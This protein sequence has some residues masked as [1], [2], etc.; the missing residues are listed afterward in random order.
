MTSRHDLTPILNRLNK[1]LHQLKPWAKR[2]QIEAFRIYDRDIPEYPFI[3]EIYGSHAVLWDRREESIDHHK[4]HHFEQTIDAICS[5][6]FE[7]KCVHVKRRAKQRPRISINHQQSEDLSANF[8]I[9]ARAEALIDRPLNAPIKYTPAYV[10]MAHEFQIREGNF[11]FLVNLDDYLDTGLFLDHRL[12]RK[13]IYDEITKRRTSHV[14]A[15]AK[16][17]MLNLFSYT[18]S[19]SVYGA[20][21]GA[22]VTSV[23]MSQNYLDWSERNFIAN[24]LMT[25]NHNFINDDVL[26]WIKS[27]FAKTTGPFDI[28]VCDPPT[29][30]NSKKMDGTWDVARDHRWLIEKCLECLNSNG[31]L[32]FSANRRDFKIDSAIKERATEITHETL[33]KDFRDAKI[34]KVFLF[35]S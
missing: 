13:M 24:G 25:S 34:R 4:Q 11:K 2:L 35:H 20:K 14:I 12:T 16:V 27:G 33:P 32:L 26:D 3:V 8:P 18:G 7:K 30:S 9:E 1:N 28:I 10:K 15:P 5:L 21:A 23:D 22:T 29:F 17:R 19:F 6:G 31:T